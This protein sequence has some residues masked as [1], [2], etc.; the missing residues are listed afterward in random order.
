MNGLQKILIVL[1]VPMG[2]LNLFGG[3]ISGIW[4]AILGEWALIGYGALVLLLSGIGLYLALIPG[5]IFGEIGKGSLGKYKNFP[6][7]ILSILSVLYIFFI[8][9]AWCITVLAFCMEQTNHSSIIPA[10]IWSYSVSTG[11]IK[12]WSDKSA[13]SGN[14]LPAIICFFIQ[15]AYISCIIGV[16]VW[17]AEITQILTTFISVMFVGFFSLYYITYRSVKLVANKA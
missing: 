14:P 4:L 15:I 6:L 12:R 17:G 5:D 2:L 3:F 8:L 10:L 9:S 13:E 7:Y 16:T 1:T 11:P